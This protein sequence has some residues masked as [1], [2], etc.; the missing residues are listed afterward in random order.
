MTDKC[1]IENEEGYISMGCSHTKKEDWERFSGNYRCKNCGIEIKNKRT[2]VK[3]IEMMYNEIRTQTLEE[4][5]KIID[6]EL[7]RLNDVP[8][9]TQNDLT[10][11]NA[12]IIDGRRRQLEYLKS[13]LLEMK[14]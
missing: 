8:I 11:R 14:K 6:K 12:E 10:K 3:F 2:F 9:S 13:K 5:E 7:Y 1:P 4:V